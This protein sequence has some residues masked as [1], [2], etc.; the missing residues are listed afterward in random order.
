MH[1]E[2]LKHQINQWVLSQIAAFGLAITNNDVEKILD[3]PWS[4]LARYKTSSGFI[5]LK[6]TPELFSLE[7]VVIPPFLTEVKSSVLSS[8]CC[9]FHRW[10][11]STY[12]HIRSFVIVSPEPMCHML[13]DFTNMT[14]KVLT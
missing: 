14:K 11:N 12:S 4:Y 1:N 6:A 10:C 9:A 7:P 8:L 2:A 5:Y 3:T 13:L